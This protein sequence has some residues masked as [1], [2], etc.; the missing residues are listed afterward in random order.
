VPPTDP[1]IIALDVTLCHK[2]DHDGGE[3]KTV[4]ASAAPSHL[5]HGD[6]LGPCP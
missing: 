1:P 5:A 6:T 2:P 3:T 4:S